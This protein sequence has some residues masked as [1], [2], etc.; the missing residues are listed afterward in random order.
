MGEL[1]CIASRCAGSVVLAL[2]VLYLPVLLASCSAVRS[3]VRCSVLL[4]VERVFI[5][6][7]L[8]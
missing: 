6:F 4:I 8:L 7:L 2:P 5:R 3:S 1:C